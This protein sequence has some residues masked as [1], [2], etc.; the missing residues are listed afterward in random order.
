MIVMLGM[1]MVYFA[2]TDSWNVYAK[3]IRQA[4]EWL[5]RLEEETD[6]KE[7]NSE[8]VSGGNATADSTT[9]EDTHTEIT[10]ETTIEATI[11]TTIETSQSETWQSETLPAEA[12]QTVSFS[13]TQIKQEQIVYGRVE[14]DY[15]SDALFIGDSRTVGLYEYGGLEEIATFYASTGLTIQKLFTA[16]IV[17]VPG[18]KEKQTIEE[19]LAEKHF[20]KIYLMI[21]INEMGSGTV[22]SFM[23]EYEAVIAHLQELQPDAIIYVQGIMKVTNQRSEQGDYIYNEGIEAR[24]VELAKLADNKNIFYL[25]VNPLICDEEGGVIADYTYDGVHLKAQYISIW[26]EFLKDNAVEKVVLD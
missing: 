17:M 6:D 26:T 12:L 3:P 4:G 21:G 13:D 9:T 7:K 5:G 24:N 20:A 25:D 8:N 1:G 18:Q 2:C 14:E 11:E 10:T 15:F 16:P 22:D 19:A 23:E